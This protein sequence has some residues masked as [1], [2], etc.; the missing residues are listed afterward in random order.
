M[1][2]PEAS[3]GNNLK[4]I[5][6]ITLTTTS[7]TTASSTTT[8]FTTTTLTTATA[9]TTTTTTLLL[10]GTVCSADER[11]LAG[12]CRTRCCLAEEGGG[13]GESGSSSSSC[14][15]CGNTGKCYTPL[16]IKPGNE[17]TANETEWLSIYN[18]DEKATLVGPGLAFLTDSIDAAKGTVE[19]IRYQLA[20]S[21]VGTTPHTTMDN[22]PPNLMPA[23]ELLDP[24][25]FDVAPKSGE[26][27][28]MPRRNGNFNMWLL[29][30]D[31]AGT[32]LRNGLSK[33]L[34]QAVVRQWSFEVTGKP[35]FEVASYARAK[36]NLPSVNPGDEPYLVNDKLG[37]LAVVVGTTY[38]I[39]PID[40]TKFTTRFASGGE[41]ARIRFTINNPP[42]GFFVEP[43]TG[44]IQG[45][46][47]AT[48]AGQT[49]EAIL[50]AFDPSGAEAQLERI[51]F[52][53]LPKP[54]FVPVFDL[55]RR[56]DSG[57]DFTEPTSHG[58]YQQSATSS[59]AD[60]TDE[61]DTYRYTVGTA[62]RIAPL[63]LDKN[64]TTV[65]TGSVDGI[66]YTLSGTAPGTFFV[67]AR[68]GQVFGQF[69]SPGNYSFK[70]LAV[71]QGGATATA[72]A[73]NFQVDPRPVFQL[74]HTGVRLTDGN[75]TADAAAG[76][77]DPASTKLY[78]IGS[79][80]KIAPLELNP[81]TTILS[82]GQF[83]DISYTLSG[84]P[85]SFFVQ[86]KTGVIFGQFE[87]SI[88]YS[89]SLL[90]VDKSGQTAEVERY[91]FQVID[92]AQFVL[93]VAAN[94][95]RASNASKYTDP[96]GAHAPT[97][98]FVGDTYKISPLQ[99]DPNAT[100]V[101]SGTFHDITFT[102]GPE[103]PGS[104]FVQAATGVVSGDFEAAGSYTFSLL[105]VD[106]TGQTQTVEVYTF[107][108]EQRGQFA[109]L[110][111][112]RK[113]NE[114]NDSSYT[115][116]TTTT[117][118]AVGNTY[119]FSSIEIKEV[120][121][122][123]DAIKDITFIVDNAP[124][125]FLIDPSDGYI[126]GT[127]HAPGVYSMELYAVDRKSNRATIETIALDVQNED[128]VLPTNGPHGVGCLHGAVVDDIPFDGRFVC[129]C[130]GTIYEGDNCD[131]E[132]QAA[133]AAAIDG[134]GDTSMFV[135]IVAGAMALFV[136]LGILIYR[137][138]LYTIKM[139]AFDFKAE[140]ARLV[141]AGEIDEAGDDGADS[142]PKIPREI[143]RANI[144]M[145]QMIGEG[146]FGEVWKAVLDESSTQGGVPGYQ[147]AVKTS[148]EAKGEGADEMLREA[149]VMAQVS[150]HPNLVS[151]IGVVTSGVPLLLAISMC[152]NGSLLSLL[153]ERK[154]KT[155]A[156]GKL[157]FT[158]AER[159]GFAIDTAKGMAH[160]TAN[161]FVHRD[162]AARNVLVD[163]TM[164][165]RVADFGL[166]RGIAGARAGPETTE[167][168]DEE[169]YY[170]S[171][172]G[173]FPVR[174]TS[175]EAMQTMRFSEATDVWSFGI[176]M[177]ELFTDGGK[178]YAGMA[179]AA[180]ISKVQG[181]YRAKQPKLC[182]DAV[183]TVML[184]CWCAKP[185][186]RPTFVQLETLLQ[187]A[188][189]D[190]GVATTSNATSGG[191]G[192]TAKKQKKK[193]KKTSTTK[194]D[195]RQAVAVNDTYMSDAPAEATRAGSRQ[196]VAVNDTYMTDEPAP[197]EEMADQYLTVDNAGGAVDAGGGAGADDE[198]LSVAA[199]LRK[200]TI[201][202]G[203]VTAKPE[204]QFGG[205]EDAGSDTEL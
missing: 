174:W 163:A 38:H 91:T 203:V 142:G 125:G 156:E 197:A 1:L 18:K 133:A 2:V 167:D 105:A 114:G 161:S 61:G 29:A 128:R 141:G 177:I 111:Y 56:T 86:A 24:G 148:K 82:D 97:T 188:V 13:G 49:F 104:F 23:G 55:H 89:F 26:I 130:S 182:T 199:G 67:Q 184:Q 30:V 153:K 168:G 126:Q 33:E 78:I 35:D 73:L 28:A 169:E 115:D 193:K 48:A 70:V 46:P 85:N 202:D 54:L 180:V 69:N 205:F 50:L 158:L 9:T 201:A 165:C 31:N 170:R 77:T 76:Y 155:K 134:D 113:S 194:A 159:I 189:E 62:Y 137:R 150:G 109:V 95:T 162:L 57:A 17:W 94:G 83:S 12:D 196:S 108:V 59:G 102:L 191:A 123:A 63:A 154:L 187:T 96:T 198:Y 37:V 131:A 45:N 42:P 14:P 183:Y 47:L 132:V 6:Q 53:V 21:P 11:C 99:I 146:A 117:T 103:A 204:E 71:D 190:A 195:Q 135:G 139:Q 186:D 110:N 40:R 22:P 106:K 140:V 72:E 178:P 152:E 171:R 4:A 157:Q 145:I 147:V 173:T 39:A 81:E 58:E 84:A 93:G 43:D 75:S 107:A 80:Y 151:L 66:T 119:R 74:G 122:T 181:G 27:S 15:V 51:V 100:Q 3:C 164:T 144:T 120:E 44:E 65:S 79:T 8:T 32:A 192:K 175:P 34:D 87:R 129:N 16:S 127:P 166:A 138:R 52:R 92:K 116:P 179:N 185:A 101:S 41:S 98:Y 143:K 160:L 36:Q 5:S 88:E 124:P 64:K 10:A 20:W 121:H 68:S 136:I 112:I 25:L 19:Q 176:V 200:G 7:S 90:A 118:Y 149:T 172:T 60:S